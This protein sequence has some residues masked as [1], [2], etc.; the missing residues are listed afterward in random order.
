MKAFPP[1]HAQ[2]KEGLRK[3]S[4]TWE[5]RPNEYN[6]FANLT[7]TSDVEKAKMFF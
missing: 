4:H 1:E 7:D 3:R 5:A 2:R 6:C